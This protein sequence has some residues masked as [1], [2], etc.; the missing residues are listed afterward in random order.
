MT[1]PC[2]FFLHRF[3]FPIPHS[4][5]CTSSLD[6]SGGPPF[7]NPRP[8]GAESATYRAGTG[9]SR[10]GETKKKTVVVWRT[11]GRPQPR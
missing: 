9:F 1:E 10:A 4:I 3:F 11:R 7:S 5:N 6:S 8:P 2:S